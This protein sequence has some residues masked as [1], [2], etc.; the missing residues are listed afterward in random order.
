MFEVA[1]V[2]PSSAE[3]TRQ[4]GRREVK[5][6]WVSIRW[7]HSLKMLLSSLYLQARS[8]GME[9]NPGVGRHPWANPFPFLVVCLLFRACVGCRELNPVHLL[10]RREGV[11][12][13]PILIFLVIFFVC[14][15]V[16]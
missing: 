12:P 11:P 9:A 6:F 2:A 15:A 1:K 5:L 3:G 8:G 13:A 10:N 4:G 14:F 7:G 16:A